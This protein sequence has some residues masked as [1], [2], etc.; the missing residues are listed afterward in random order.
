MFSKGHCNP[1]AIEKAGGTARQPNM[2][3]DRFKMSRMIKQLKGP[4]PQLCVLK[5][6]KPG[7]QG[8]TRALHVVTALQHLWNNDRNWDLPG[9][10]AALLRRTWV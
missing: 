6:M 2:D 4:P 7:K 10:E 3:N 8:G 1:P 9:R 5:F